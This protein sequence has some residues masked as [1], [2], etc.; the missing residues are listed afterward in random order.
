MWLLVLE[1]AKVSSQSISYCDGN[2]PCSHLLGRFGPLLWIC[3]SLVILFPN[4]TSLHFVSCPQLH[5]MPLCVLPHGEIIGPSI[6]LKRISSKKRL[7]WNLLHLWRSEQSYSA[8]GLGKMKSL[9]SLNTTYGAAVDSLPPALIV[10]VGWAPGINRPQSPVCLEH[11]QLNVKSLTKVALH[12]HLV[13]YSVSKSFG[14]LFFFF[15][16]PRIEV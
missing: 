2:I 13:N 4:N 15:C 16:L 10:S 1:P 9:F 6:I 5:F 14:F 11:A 3:G 12:S 8:G 7:V